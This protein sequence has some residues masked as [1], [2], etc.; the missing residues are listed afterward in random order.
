MGKSVTPS[1]V[2]YTKELSES[3]KNICYKLDI[4]VHF[5]RGNT[6]KNLLVAPKDKYT[7]TEKSGVI[8]R[9][10][11]DRAEFDEYIG[12]VL[13]ERLKEHL[14]APSPHYDLSNITGRQTS[15]VN[16]TIVGRQ[17]HNFARTIKEAI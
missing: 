15:E 11:C 1:I 10:K 5:K 2:C 8:Q 4:Q 9:Y 13:W 6:I 14:R 12:E 7:I 3:F 17:S 16:F